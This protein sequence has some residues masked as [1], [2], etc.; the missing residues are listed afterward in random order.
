MGGKSL[1]WEGEKGVTVRR[2]RRRVGVGNREKEG[3]YYGERFR[4]RD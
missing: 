1:G 4:A 3:V 2:E